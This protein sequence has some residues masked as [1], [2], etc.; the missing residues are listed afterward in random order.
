MAAPVLSRLAIAGLAYLALGACGGD[1]GGGSPSPSP[2]P[3]PSSGPPSVSNLAP[4]PF[5]ITAT[6]QLAVV[7]WQE[8][9]QTAAAPIVAL[10]SEKFSL[11]WSAS[12]KTYTAA[13]ADFGSGRLVYTFP[14][15][16][17]A[18]FSLVDANGAKLPVYVSIFLQTSAMGK[19][20]W[21]SADGITPFTRGSYISVFLPALCR[22]P[23]NGSL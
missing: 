7:G 3:T 1:D 5:G 17:P 16:N 22:R 18:A 15:N 21:Q 14:G 13:L 6:T 11:G 10:A 12:E 9:H 2:T 8:T 19:L 4:A 23:E 20:N